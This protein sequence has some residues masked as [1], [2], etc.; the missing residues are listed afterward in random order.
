MVGRVLAVI[1]GLLWVATASVSAQESYRVERLAEGVYAALAVPGG[2]ATSNAM[3]VVTHDWVLASGAHM[4][5]DAVTDLLAAIG[6]VTPRPVDYFIL[7]HH[8]RGFAF[9]DFDFP[10]DMRVIMSGQTWAGLQSEVPAV[11]YPT[12]FFS[13]GLTL[14]SA[15]HSVVLSNLGRGHAEGDVIVFLPESDILFASDLLYVDSI[16]FLGDGHMEDWVLALEFVE[17]L[18]PGR[19]IPGYG[20]VSGVEAVGTFKGFLRAF[21]S[22]VLRPLAAGKPLEQ[23]KREFSLPRFEDMPGYRQF[24]DVNLERAYRDLQEGVLS[25]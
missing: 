6:E 21:L 5:R 7:P 2:R 4:T 17:Q 15:Q 9:T 18:N 11:I 12:M 3:F 22:A 10:A 16:G 23:V 25:R 13:E 20:R 14:K 8:H 1:A 19:I 24:L